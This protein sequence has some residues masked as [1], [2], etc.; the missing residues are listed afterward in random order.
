MISSSVLRWAEVG[1][2]HVLRRSEILNDHCCGSQITWM[3]TCLCSAA[4]S[5]QI[6][7]DWVEHLAFRENLTSA[8]ARKVAEST[9]G[10]IVFSLV[11]NWRRASSTLAKVIWWKL[12]ECYYFSTSNHLN[13]TLGVNRRVLPLS[14]ESNSVMPSVKNC[15]IPPDMELGKKWTKHFR[16][17]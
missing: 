3:G 15:E 17:V 6:Q 13:W 12:S 14:P 10:T 16:R 4:H 8:T 9:L 11:S 7:K 5:P 1:I 2:Y